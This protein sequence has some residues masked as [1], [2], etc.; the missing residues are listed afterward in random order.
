MLENKSD[1]NK[2]KVTLLHEEKSRNELS[3]WML[4]NLTIGRYLPKFSHKHRRRSLLVCLNIHLRESIFLLKGNS[5][6]TLIIEMMI[7]K[8]LNGLERIKVLLHRT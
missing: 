8:I 4:R 7:Q 6:T 5:A 3:F 2:V 1:L